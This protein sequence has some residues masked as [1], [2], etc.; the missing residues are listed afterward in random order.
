MPKFTIAKGTKV[1]E[2]MPDFKGNLSS[3]YKSRNSD[4]LAELDPALKFD[5]TKKLDPNDIEKELEIGKDDGESITIEGMPTGLFENELTVQ[6]WKPVKIRGYT[7]S[8]A[9]N[10]TLDQTRIEKTPAVGGDF[11]FLYATYQNERTSQPIDTFWNRLPPP[12]LRE[13]NKVQTPWL[14]AFLH[15]PHMIRPAAQLRMPRFHFGK[16]EKASSKETDIA[17]QLLRRA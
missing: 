6:L 15:D 14:T 10:L 9:D 13:G 1:A 4:Y 8:V 11:P 12:L 2:A 5:P 17:G 3:S 16:D 7:F